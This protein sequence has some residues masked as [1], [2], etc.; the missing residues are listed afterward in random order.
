MTIGVAAKAAG[1]AIDTVRY[2]ER[3]GLLA[4]A[5]R[6]EGG[7]RL[8]STRDIERLQFIRKAKAL[9]FTLDD[10]A[11][12][13]RLQDG[14]GTRARVRER[15]QARIAELDRKIQAFTA[16]RDALATLEHCCSGQGPV[17][18]CPIMEGV[19]SLDLENPELENAAPPLTRRAR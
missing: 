9:G 17:A 3:Q 1:V 7:F 18:G 14:G 5:P 12:L 6:T 8:F 2:Y 11:E 16:I 19:R 4:D 10:I 13:L 15:A